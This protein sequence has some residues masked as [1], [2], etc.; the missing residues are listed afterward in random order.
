MFARACVCV[1]VCVR[2]RARVCV[3]ERQT[4]RQKDRQTEGCSVGGRSVFESLARTVT[5]ASYHQITQ[6]RTS[7]C[8][9]Q[10][11][12]EVITAYSACSG[13]RLGIQQDHY[14]V[15]TAYSAYSG[16]RLGIQQ[17][18][19]EIMTAYSAYFGHRLGIQT[20]SASLGNPRCT[21]VMDITVIIIS[22][23]HIITII[24]NTVIV[25]IISI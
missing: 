1:C 3:C 4:D 6:S 12:Y 7:A 10:D 16:H 13:H 20:Q 18:H 15:I 22:R 24:T 17:D 9:K 2:A 25:N 5:S 23:F 19:Y 21:Q 14:E 8:Q 11:H